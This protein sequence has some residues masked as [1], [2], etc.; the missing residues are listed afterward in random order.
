MR[1]VGCVFG[2]IQTNGQHHQIEFLFLY[3][4]TVSRISDGY[5]IGLRDLPADTYIA[6]DEAYVGQLFRALIVTFE[7]FA[8]G[9]DIVMEHR[10]IQVGTV[11]LGQD[12]LLLGIGTAYRGTIGIT[13]GDDLPGT[14]ALD[15]RNPVWMFTVR[16]TS[17]FALIGTGGRDDAF[18]FKTGNDVFH[19]A[20]TE[21]TTL[22][23]VEYVVAGCQ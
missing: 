12:H 3:S 4:L 23:R 17:D 20:V 16:R 1:E 9:A 15:P 21:V 19:L 5:V 7:V 11:V 6:P 18:I 2:R 10:G 22:R 8:E 14:N 13:P